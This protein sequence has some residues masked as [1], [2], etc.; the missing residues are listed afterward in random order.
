[1]DYQSSRH[2]CFIGAGFV[3]APSAA[4]CALHNPDIEVTVADISSSRIE[5]WQSDSLPIYEPGL[6]EVLHQV[7]VRGNLHFTT[8]VRKAIADAD[9]IFICVNTPTKSIGVG[10]GSAADIAYVESATLMIAEAAQND[11]IIIE[12]STVPVRTADAI[13][14]I[15][16]ANQRSGVH[17]E[18]LSNPEFLA[19]G[20]AIN[21]LMRPDRVL[22]G[23]LP[24]PTGRA[25]AASL[26]SLYAAWVPTEA[27]IHT[28]LWSSEL[29]K[30]AA[31]ALLAQRI[32]S[33]NSLSAICEAVGADIEQVASIVG[34]DS[35]IGPGMLKSSVGF[36]GSCFRKDVAN[37]CY[38]AESLHLP[39]VAR[40]WQGVLDINIWQKERFSRRI[41]HKLNNTLVGKRIAVCGFSYKRLTGDARES[42]AISVVRTLVAE[43]ASVCIFDP[44]VKEDTIWQELG[45]D[46]RADRIKICSD[47]Y[48]ATKGA[49]AVAL[50]T[51][52]DEFGNK[53]LVKKTF[54]L[55]RVDSG[56]GQDTKV[57]STKSELK[58][59][60]SSRNKMAPAFDTPQQDRRLDWSRVASE[61]QRPRYV[62]D[63]RN[64]VDA[65]ALGALG[66]H[67][68]CIGKGLA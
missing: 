25:A 20:T 37:L 62:F 33:I 7:N 1:M 22:I 56:V 15:L 34:A 66:F 67:V 46:V 49:H 10:A 44:C 36:G 48:E 31:N 61:M 42:P 43:G 39:E 28:T 16:D 63:G 45:P 54:D 59:S 55:R 4:V 13:R 53:P 47:A 29:A 24:T 30:L 21:D 5:A 68:E 52:W 60:L 35:R 40:Y 11:K 3:G 32:S 2:V 38:L 26:A 50:L 58:Q 64:I 65:E 14:S 23:S 12:K 9:T 51:D 57:Q 41:I 8:D 19:E 27:I 6:P 18:I 17:F